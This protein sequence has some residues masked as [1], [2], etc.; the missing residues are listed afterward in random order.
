MIHVTVP[1]LMTI[2]RAIEEQTGKLS[3]AAALSASFPD[4]LSPGTCTYAENLKKE[5]MTSVSSSNRI[6]RT[7]GG[8]AL[9]ALILIAIA[10]IAAG[11]FM[12]QREQ[13]K[14]IEGLVLSTKELSSRIEA[15]HKA[16][17][18]EDGSA[19]GESESAPTLEFH[20]A[21]DIAKRL[22]P[23]VADDSTRDLALGIAEVSNWL[24]PHGEEA[25]SDRIVADHL[26]KLSERITTEVASLDSQALAA[27]DGKTASSLFAE[28]AALMELYPVPDSSDRA[29]VLKLKELLAA[30]AT[31]QQKIQTAQRLRY[32]LW[33]LGLI[34]KGYQ[35]FNAKV[36][37]VQKWADNDILT[38]AAATIL[39]PIQAELL[40]A[41]AL[42]LYMS[43]LR[44]VNSE[45]DESHQVQL[46][47]RLNAAEV[48]RYLE[49][50]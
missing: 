48:K 11:F 49:E 8:V 14:K 7:S 41:S 30:R 42:E 2:P 24:F 20:S 50:F 18:L 46:S 10:A 4:D 36:A 9:E 33:A 45:I 31:V 27:T 39:S 12:L 5:S 35:D 17:M 16:R 34:E 21:A 38:D 29:A 19:W 47:K 43:L 3:E 23:L 44:K 37:K 13:T 6:G 25:E 26:T 15:L 28:G 1:T 22:D 40:D 32:N